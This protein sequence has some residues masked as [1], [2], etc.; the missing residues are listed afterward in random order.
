MW[1][2]GL[3]VTC[4]QSCLW[5]T[6]PHRLISGCNYTVWCTCTFVSYETIT[7]QV[8]NFANAPC[9]HDFVLW[10]PGL[11]QVLVNGSLCM[12]SVSSCRTRMDFL[13]TGTMEDLWWRLSS[14]NLGM[15]LYLQVTSFLYVCVHPWQMWVQFPPYRLSSWSTLS[16]DEEA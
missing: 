15:W 5:C 10:S 16:E 7:R 1:Q 6:G 3:C 9:M 2:G 8:C 11:P 14:F 12:R 13:V 4:D